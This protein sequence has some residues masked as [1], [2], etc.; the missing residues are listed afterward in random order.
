[1]PYVIAR[2]KEDLLAS[3]IIKCADVLQAIK[4]VAA[5]WKK[6]SGTT[7]KTVFL[8][9]ELPQTN[10]VNKEFDV[11]YK[12][13]AAQSECDMTAEEYLDFDGETSSSLPA[14]NSDVVVW[15]VISVQSCVAEYLQEESGT[16]LVEVASENDDEDDVDEECTEVDKSKEE[17]LAMIDKLVNFKDLDREERQSLVSLKEKF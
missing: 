1:M 8:N 6:V 12:E 13:F 15:R 2:A 5:A 17:V 3:E 11:L 9:V 4:R 10:K 14:N 7:I 16:D